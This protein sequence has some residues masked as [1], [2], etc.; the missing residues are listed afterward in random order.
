MF[1]LLVMLG[2]LLRVSIGDDV[3][4]GSVN[5]S[6]ETKNT[7][8]LGFSFA[9]SD[10]MGMALGLASRQLHGCTSA[11]LDA[12]YFYVYGCAV[13]STFVTNLESEVGTGFLFTSD[14]S[15]TLES[16]VT[17]T[18]LLVAN[19]WDLKLVYTTPEECNNDLVLVS[20]AHGCSLTGPQCGLTKSIR[21]GCG[22]ATCSGCVLDGFF[23]TYSFATAEFM[24]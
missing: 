9:D 18:S 16:N 15:L 5:L 13:P 23:D 7:A 2:C 11:P 8:G 24:T 22:S 1:V 6:K 20:N 3:G 10:S 12:L 17:S 4:K 14:K 19:Y 21:V